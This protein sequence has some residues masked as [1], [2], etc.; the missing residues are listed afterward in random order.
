METED[1]PEQHFLGMRMVLKQSQI[2][3]KIGYMF[4]TVTKH[5]MNNGISIIGPPLAI[6][7]S[8][9]GDH[10]DVECGFPVSPEST[11]SGDVIPGV[12][13][14]SKVAIAMHLGPYDRLEI[15][16]NE[17]MTWIEANGYR[18]SGPPWEVYLTDPNVEPD[19]ERWMTKIFCPITK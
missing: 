2:S 5:C 19:P 12:I 3:E 17:V 6:Y 15:T 16:Y 4:E 9:E 10:M 18:L 8:Y 14:M 11:G 7:H 1:V 13:P